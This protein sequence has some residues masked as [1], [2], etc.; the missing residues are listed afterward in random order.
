MTSTL[1]TNRYDYATVF[2]DH[3]YRY[4][5]MHLQKIASSED[6][7]EGK[8][9]FERMASS[10]GIIINQYHTDNGIL[11]ANCWVQDCQ[12]RANPQITTY[13]GVDDHHTNGLGERRIR[14]IQDKFRY[15]MIHSQHKCPEA[16]TYNLWPYD[17][18]HSNNAY[19]SIP[20][21]LHPQVLSPLHF[22]TG[23][24]VQDNPTHWN[25]FGCPNYILNE[26]L[27]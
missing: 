19:Y 8:H 18:R 23:N 20:L 12:E 10:H 1:T 5:Y 16:I 3:F 25:S 11:R 2:V 21:L 7:L 14:D 17:L 26:A 4:S 9:A 24:Q 27:C 13:D 22:F 6:N 15:M